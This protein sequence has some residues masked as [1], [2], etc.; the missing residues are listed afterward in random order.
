MTEF[1][2]KFPRPTEWAGVI[3]NPA[4]E[5]CFREA[6]LTAIIGLEG[7]AISLKFDRNS[8]RYGLR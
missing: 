1:G 8:R 5:N 7:V 2:A 3:V 6:G 4:Q